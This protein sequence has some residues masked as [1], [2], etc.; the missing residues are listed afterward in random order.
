MS[1]RRFLPLP[2]DLPDIGAQ[3]GILLTGGA[4]LMVPR[5]SSR[6]TKVRA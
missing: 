3:F 2:A 6:R 5:C 1:F 4:V